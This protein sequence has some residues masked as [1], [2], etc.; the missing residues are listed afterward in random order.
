MFERRL[1]IFLMFLLVFVAC[2][3]VRSV[4]LQ[5]VQGG[6]WRDEAAKSM[7]SETYTETSRGQIVDCKGAVLARDE[8]CI[9]AAVEYAAI[10]DPPEKVW[11]RT[12]SEK[13][14]KDRL[15]DDYKALSSSKRREM[16]K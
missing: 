12:F 10:I 3:L 8:P 2:L 1:K 13:R 16:L 5:V 14:L 6:Y 11:L 15:G 9:D 4:Q 7:R